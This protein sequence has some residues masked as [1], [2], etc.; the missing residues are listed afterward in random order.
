MATTFPLILQV[1]TFLGV[2]SISGYR[3]PFRYLG[4]AMNYG[5]GVPNPLPQPAPAV[6]APVPTATQRQVGA[7]GVNL[8]AT[9]VAAGSA[10]LL[11]AARIVDVIGF[12]TAVTPTVEA[13]VSSAIWFH[14]ADGFIWAGGMT[15]L[16]THDL[17]EETPVVAPPS[18][19]AAEA[20]ESGPAGTPD[21]NPPV[22]PMGSVFL[23]VREEVARELKR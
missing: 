3:G 7:K 5:G 4:W 11:P 21:G 10:T 6:V 18:P 2:Q 22:H 15:D 1:H 8:R 14:I 20:H 13:G 17:Q 9:A 23:P 12:V 16:G 19:A